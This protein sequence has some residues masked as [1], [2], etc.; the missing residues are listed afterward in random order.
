MVLAILLAGLSPAA[1]QNTAPS[2]VPAIPQD[3]DPA[4]L[5]AA[6]ELLEAANLEKQIS[7]TFPTA[8]RKTGEIILPLISQSLPN[9][10]ARREVEKVFAGIV[11]DA[12]AQFVSHRSE[13][14]SLTAIAYARVLQV[15]DLKA[16]TG[17][18]RSPVGQ[19]LNTMTPEFIAE[20]TPKIA[21]LMLGAPVADGPQA[22]P[23][24]LKAAK[25]M[26]AASRME[27]LF[28]GAAAPQTVIRPD[29]G[30]QGAGQGEIRAKSIA[31]IIAPKRAALLDIIAAA[32]AN[33]FTLAELQEA[34][35]FYTSDRGRTV[36]AAMPQLIAEQNR[37][38][39]GLMTEMQETLARKMVETLEKQLAK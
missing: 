18:Y 11:S 7:E 1:A 14:V 24:R 36:A 5:Q 17:F 6:R 12:E 29:G 37:V 22:D 15:D 16:M 39:A 30:K 31:D 9:D 32:Y 28:D 10:E 19:K 3:V 34:T 25:A 21:N 23:E 2:S 8:M 26:I 38:M 33:K 13:F 27:A 20:A 4:R 35:A